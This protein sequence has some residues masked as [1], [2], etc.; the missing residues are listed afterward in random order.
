MDGSMMERREAVASLG[1]LFVLGHPGT[2]AGLH[3][4]RYLAEGI[5]RPGRFHDHIFPREFVLTF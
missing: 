4:T 5:K 3:F 1:E 2:K